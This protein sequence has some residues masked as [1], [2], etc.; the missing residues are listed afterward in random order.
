MTEERHV[1]T[2]LGRAIVATGRAGE[3]TL[4]LDIWGSTLCAAV[5]LRYLAIA[6]AKAVIG[7]VTAMGLIGLVLYLYFARPHV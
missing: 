3:V 6:V 4:K 2:A 5:D 1:D 7:T